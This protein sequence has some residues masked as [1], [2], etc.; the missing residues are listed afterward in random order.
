[1]ISYLLQIP[2]RNPVSKRQR[3]KKGL[4]MRYIPRFALRLLVVALTTVPFVVFSSCEESESPELPSAIN[5][6]FGDGQYSKRGTEL[7]DPLGVK[8]TFGDGSPAAGEIIQFRVVAGGG[9]VS[10]GDV[11]AGSGGVA[12]TRL[13][14][15]DELG[16]NTVRATLATDKS[17][18][19]EFNATG[20]EFYCE[21]EDPTFTRKF[22]ARGNLFLFTRKSRLN[23]QGGQTV[24][25]I[26]K[27]QTD[28]PG[29]K[30]A[31]TS[32]RKFTEGQTITVVRDAAFSPAGDFFLSWNFLDDEVLKVSTGF[33]TSHFASL[34][35]YL[36]SEIT[37]TPNGILVGCDEAGPFVVGCR[38]TLFRFAEAVYGGTQGD[39]V[40]ND[41][42]AVDPNTE[43]IYFIYL[44]DA[45]LRRLPVDTLVATDTVQTVV[46]LT[47]DEASG[48]NGMVCDDDGT[49]YILVDTGN[50]KQI[51][52][53][54]SAGA[55]STVF[56]F[57]DRGPDDAAGMQND[58]AMWRVSPNEL[59]LYTVDTL[60]DVLL[61]YRIT[62]QEQE[63][64][65]M[66][67]DTAGG[68]DLES[69]STAASYGERVGLVV[70]P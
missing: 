9:S 17:K 67:P 56:D 63:L 12:S 20:G 31:A 46:Q 6:V 25:G 16:T 7:P 36:G 13:T 58:L 45:T 22:T 18:F 60:N 14:L 53:V 55:K 41:A 64:I 26:V 1:M 33:A 44:P 61:T 2:P 8:V 66:M 34:D 68:Y 39:D 40:N 4:F 32:V 50:T 15:G 49:V 28:I 19:V 24:S 10:R 47:W 35:S 42:V 59:L 70:L 11:A 52:S 30:L 23:E 65:V 54:T 57:F 38:D 5:V 29:G 69:I 62:E 43:D 51:V 3:K 37:S 21:E 27:I 48:A